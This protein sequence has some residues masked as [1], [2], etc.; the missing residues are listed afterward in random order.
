MTPKQHQAHV[1]QTI[2]DA[3]INFADTATPDGTRRAA[4][5]LTPLRFTTSSTCNM[6]TVVH[7]GSSALVDI[8]IDED[9]FEQCDER[10]LAE[11]ITRTIQHGEKMVRDVLRQA[12]TRDRSTAT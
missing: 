12:V 11:L 5:R 8:K 7:N 3:G 2:R 6:I 1:L 4:S 10:Q 9:A